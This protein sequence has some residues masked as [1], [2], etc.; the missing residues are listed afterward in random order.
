MGPSNFT[1]DL[2][3]NIVEKRKSG[4]SDRRT[5][6]PKRFSGFFHWGFDNIFF[7]IVISKNGKVREGGD[8]CGE[9][10]SLESVGPPSQNVE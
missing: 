2:H 6:A 5:N 10:R 1:S 8:R 9:E 3:D 7:S 4:R